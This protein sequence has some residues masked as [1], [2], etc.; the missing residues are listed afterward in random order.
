MS[1]ILPS[2]LVPVPA[3]LLSV[4]QIDQVDAQLAAA[5]RLDPARHT[6]LGLVTADSDDALYVALDEVT[7]HHEV[8]VVFAKS[9]YAGA[10]HAS[11]P[12]SG[13]VMGVLA[14]P[15]PDHIADALWGLREAL[16]AGISFHT[17]PGES[18]PAFFAHV[19]RETGRFLAPQADL[20]PGQPMAYLIAPPLESTV[21]LDAALKAADVRLAKHLPPPSE[22]NFGGGYLVGDLAELEAAAVAFV[23]AIRVISARPLEALRRPDRLRR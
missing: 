12:F 17:F 3:T 20:E 22:T 1:G 19:I 10:K 4:R 21:G 14:A 8:E 5:M 7:K 13:E 18:Q 2:D 6:S 9:F 16:Q 15:H 23:E 11:G